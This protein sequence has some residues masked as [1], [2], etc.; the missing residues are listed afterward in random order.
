M[1]VVVILWEIGSQIYKVIISYYGGIWDGHLGKSLEVLR[2]SY[3]AL[4]T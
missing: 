2:L 4:E 1:I 3:E